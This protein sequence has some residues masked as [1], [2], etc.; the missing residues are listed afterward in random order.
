MKTIRFGIIGAGLM[1]RELASLTARWCHLPGMDVK[2]E[3]VAVCD[4]NPDI[5]PWYEDNF[6]SIKL[7]TDDYRKVVESPDVDLVYCAVPHNLHEQFYTE[8]VSAGNFRNGIFYHAF[9]S[10][11]IKLRRR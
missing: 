1:G 3:L 6:A 4:K 2:P 9:A 7:V 11:W 10:F 5:L 8:I